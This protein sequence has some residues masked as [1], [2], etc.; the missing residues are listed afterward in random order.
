MKVRE[1]TRLLESKGWQHVRKTGSHRIFKNPSE[2]KVVTVAGKLSED[3]PIG[4]LKSIRKIA[5]LE[6]K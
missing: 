6:E 3:V 1:L 5:G 2:P 4:I